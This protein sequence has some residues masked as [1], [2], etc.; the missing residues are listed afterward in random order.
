MKLTKSLQNFVKRL[1]I[2]Y[3]WHFVVEKFC[4]IFVKSQKKIAK[5]KLTKFFQTFVN[6]VSAFC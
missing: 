2:Y 6:F 1:L 4:L 3:F 5:K